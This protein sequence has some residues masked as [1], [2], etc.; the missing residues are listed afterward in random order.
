MESGV[1]FESTSSAAVL[2][3]AEAFFA[4]VEEI[5]LFAAA[6]PRCGRRVQSL[7]MVNDRR[8]EYRALHTS[9]LLIL[10]QTLARVSLVRSGHPL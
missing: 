5:N 1:H 10:F 7:S 4:A 2:V 3:D 6:T 8:Q 9:P